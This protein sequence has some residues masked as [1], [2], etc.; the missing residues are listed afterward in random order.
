MSRIIGWVFILSLVALGA[1]AHA[2]DQPQQ[3]PGV[4]TGGDA[5]K[6][7]SSMSIE[8]STTKGPYYYQSTSELA[9]R[10]LARGVANVTLCVAEI[11]NQMFQEAYRTSPVSGAVVGVW[12]GVIKGSKRLA[13]GVWEVAT[14]YCPT[15][16]HYQPYI[17]PEVVFMEYLH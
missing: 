13:I 12:K 6:G 3:G 7:E 15:K 8:P 4:A 2:A 10:K 14:F 11:P 5:L 9:A 17:E 1:A 16:N